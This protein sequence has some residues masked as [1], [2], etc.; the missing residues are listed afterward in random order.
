[1]TCA[2]PAGRLS[3]RKPT[4]G[5]C[6]VTP[7]ALK[8]TIRDENF[9]NVLAGFTKTFGSPSSKY[10][11]V[12]CVAKTALIRELVDL[13]NH[14]VHSGANAITGKVLLDNLVKSGIVHPVP[15]IDPDD[16]QPLDRFF[17]IGLNDAASGLDPIEL[18][19]AMVSDGVVCYFTAIQFHDLSTQ[20]PTHHHI[21]RILNPSPR[22][23]KIS[24]DTPSPG[25]STKRAPQKRDRLGT[26]QFL[27]RAIPY[28]ITRRE[29]R[30]I[31]GIQKRY[32]TNKTVFSITTYE[33]TLLD[34]LDRPLSCGGSSVVFEAW[35]NAS[36]QLDQDRLL[37]CLKTIN[38]D[39]LSRRVGYMLVEHLQNQLKTDLK[40]YLYS[41]Q[42]RWCKP[43]PVTTIALLPG[44]EFSNTNLD[45]CL[46]VP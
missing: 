3:G 40:D 8:N 5:G 38:D 20:I 26:R 28:Y 16:S 2:S 15:L 21:A 39:R 23:S 14:L 25:I 6:T 22:R 29:S 17:S 7:Q 37:N 46:K 10:P 33:Q 43:K 1:M 24:N 4:R 34:T 36:N 9:T 45:W 30:R 44:Y 32:Y 35:K 31:P 18:L 12:R 42:R 41:V 19:Q 13:R 11:N 27:Y